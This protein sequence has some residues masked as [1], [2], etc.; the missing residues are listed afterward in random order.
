MEG[1]LPVNK[2]AGITSFFLIPILR[3]LTGVKKIGHTGTLDPFAI[4]L[5]LYLIGPRFTRQSDLYLS[6][7]KE[8]IARLALGTSTDTHDCEGTILSHTKEIPSPLE[9]EHSLA[10]FQGWQEQIPPLYSAKKWGGRKFYEYARKGEAPPRTPCRVYMEIQILDD[11]AL[12]ELLLHV[13][14]SKGTYI[15]GLARD[16]GE[17]L[18]CGAHLTGLQRTRIGT[19]DLSLAYEGKRLL[20]GESSSSDLLIHLRE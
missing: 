5:M 16:L 9:I 15:R 8:Y 7:E 14:C 11:S 12:P 17:A 6:Q 2:P 18:G 13:R 10:S 4:G 20:A 1:I 3:K 19:F